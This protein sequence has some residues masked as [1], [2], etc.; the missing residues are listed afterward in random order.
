M[1]KCVFTYF[2]FGAIRPIIA[3]FFLKSKP[4]RPRRPA[5]EWPHF[6]KILLELCRRRDYNENPG[7]FL[8]RDTIRAELQ[9]VGGGTVHRHG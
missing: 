7:N 1:I 3:E 5:A 6:L 9:S 4:A 2:S 8:G